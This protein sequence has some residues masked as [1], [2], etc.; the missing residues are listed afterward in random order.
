[1]GGKAV[2]KNVAYNSYDAQKT[3]GDGIDVK[4]RA[5]VVVAKGVTDIVVNIQ[6][7]FPVILDGD[8]EEVNVE[9]SD[10]CAVV[11]GS[12]GKVNVRKGAQKAEIQVAQAGHVGRMK[13]DEE[14]LVLAENINEVN[15]L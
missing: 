2:L 5:R 14:V 12:I 6:S 4:G 1:M 9:I 10:A 3:H 15:I 7:S 8:I 13:A 11:E